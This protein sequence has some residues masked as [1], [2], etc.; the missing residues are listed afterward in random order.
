MDQRHL[1]GSGCN[2]LQCGIVSLIWSP[3]E[4][5]SQLPP[6]VFGCLTVSP[7]ML[8]AVLPGQP[9]PVACFVKTKKMNINVYRM[10]A[11]VREGGHQSKGCCCL[12]LGVLN[13]LHSEGS[14]PVGMHILSTSDVDIFFSCQEGS[15]RAAV[16]RSHERKVELSILN[17]VD[18]HVSV[19]NNQW[20]YIANTREWVVCHRT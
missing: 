12:F 8:N 1:S 2:W 20:L 16:N 14:N 10:K 19:L 11:A 18:I 13:R 5:D 15:Y 3:G 17:P 7:L 4:G 9:V 6:Y